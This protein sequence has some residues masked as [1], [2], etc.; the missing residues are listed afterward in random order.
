MRGA[1]ACVAVGR[2]AGLPLW[3][4]FLA[5]AQAPSLGPSGR[6]VSRTGVTSGRVERAASSCRCS[7]ELQRP[8]GEIGR[9]GCGQSQSCIPL[10]SASCYL[11]LSAPPV[12]VVPSN[13]RY[14]LCEHF[15]PISGS[16]NLPQIFHSA[17]ALLTATDSNPNHARAPPRASPS[18]PAHQKPPALQHH[19]WPPAAKK[20]A[21]QKQDAKTR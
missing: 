18:L 9:I 12:A 4:L 6:R 8:R 10:F 5:Q 20:L 19:D 15:M 21:D 1:G 14:L 16:C 11:P 13:N 2:P 17:S 3:F 7:G